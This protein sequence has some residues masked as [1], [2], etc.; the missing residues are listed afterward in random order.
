MTK[1]HPYQYVYFNNLINKT[2]LNKKFDLDYWGLS[3]K[4]NFEFLLKNE[5]EKEFNIY[6]LSHNK[7]FYALFSLNEKNRNKFNVVSNLADAKYIFTNFYM[8]R[9]LINKFD[10]NGYYILNE[11]IVDG[12]S[13][14]RIY[15]KKD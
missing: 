3:Y 6:N 1:N 2:E 15:K 8:D 9:D 14:N 4:Q 7:L 5:N 11:I 10:L 12:Y 13:V